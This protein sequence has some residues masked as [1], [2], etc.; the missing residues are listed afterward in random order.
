MENKPEFDEVDLNR[1]YNAL[2]Y[3]CLEVGDN[4]PGGER[5]LRATQELRDYIGK[6]LSCQVSAKSTLNRIY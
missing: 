4:G 6:M 3:Y 5:E 1:I 2:N